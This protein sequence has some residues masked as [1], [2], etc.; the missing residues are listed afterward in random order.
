MK[1]KAGV[2]PEGFGIGINFFDT[3]DM[4]SLERA[5][6]LLSGLYED[7]LPAVKRSS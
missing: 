2:Y 6:R 1:K 3:A 4:Y 5:K 7:I